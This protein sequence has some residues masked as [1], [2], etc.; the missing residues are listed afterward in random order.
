MLCFVWTTGPHDIGFLLAM[1]SSTSNGS[2][3][4]GFYRAL[5]GHLCTHE[6]CG[7]RTIR[8]SGNYGRK[9]LG[10]SQFNVRNNSIGVFHLN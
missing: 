9:F 2:I 5:D 1:S 8:K 6:N 3:T 7:L 4:S 10:C